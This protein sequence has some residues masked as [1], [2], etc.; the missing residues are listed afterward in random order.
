M[1]DLF[2]IWYRVLAVGVV[3]TYAYFGTHITI[4][5]WDVLTGADTSTKA[6]WRLSFWALGMGGGAF[7]AVAVLIFSHA[8]GV[9][10]PRLLKEMR[11]LGPP[12]PPPPMP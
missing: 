12:P 2:P 6:I 3:L 5:S 10:Q 11:E 9:M 8:M 4:L 7:Y 1:K